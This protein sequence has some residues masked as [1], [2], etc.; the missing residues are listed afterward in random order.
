LT[1]AAVEIENDLACLI[2][3]AEAMQSRLRVVTD[4][5]FEVARLLKEEEDRAAQHPDEDPVEDEDDEQPIEG[6]VVN[7]TWTSSGRPCG[8]TPYKE[9]ADAIEFTQWLYN[10]GMVPQIVSEPRIEPCWF[11]PSSRRIYVG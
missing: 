4:A 11:Y 7:A 10:A 1:H 9:Y 5:A 6:F 8:Y 3:N 2:V